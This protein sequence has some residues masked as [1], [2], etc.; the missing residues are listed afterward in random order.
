MGGSLGASRPGSARSGGRGAAWAAAAA[1]GALGGTVVAGVTGVGNVFAGGAAGAGLGWL[2][3]TG[4]GCAC[5]TGTAL[6]L[7]VMEV[8]D[9]TGEGKGVN[10]ADERFDAVVETISAAWETTGSPPETE[11]AFK[12]AAGAGAALEVEGAGAAAAVAVVVIIVAGPEA[13]SEV[14]PGG[15]LEVVRR[16]H[17]A[18]PFPS[19]DALPP[20]AVAVAVASC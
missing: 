11:D 8:D 18:G 16:L 20:F 14:G 4:A 19:V 12:T 17:G 5:P 1:I 2:T 6:L 13:R 7:Y 3:A 10:D 9:K 15:G